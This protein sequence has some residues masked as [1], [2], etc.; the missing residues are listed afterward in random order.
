[1]TKAA[2]LGQE[3]EQHVH[4][5]VKQFRPL[6]F[7]S[8]FGFAAFESDD[9]FEYYSNASQFGLGLKRSPG[10]GLLYGCGH[11]SLRRQ[12]LNGLSSSTRCAIVLPKLEQLGWRQIFAHASF[13][14][15]YPN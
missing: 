14:G 11:T 8:E 5:L 6:S 12:F 2:L 1:M 9:I 10:K 7:T 4:H 13:G 15:R 3:I